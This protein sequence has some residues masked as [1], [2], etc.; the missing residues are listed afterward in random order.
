MRVAIIHHQYAKKGGMETYLLDLIEGFWAYGDVVTVI[1]CQADPELVKANSLCRVEKKNIWLPR[2]WRKFCFMSYINNFFRHDEYDLSLSLTRTASQNAV[3]CGGTHM[4]YLNYLQK[5]LVG[6]KD[7]IEIYF[8]RKS[9]NLSPYIVAHSS[10]LRDELISL[11][12]ADPTK[13][14]LFYPPVNTKAF[15]R[16]FREKRSMFMQKFALKTNKINLLFPSTGHKRKGWCELAKAMQLLPKEQFELI[17]VGSK[18]D[19]SKQSSNIRS[20]GFVH[21]M[22]ELYAAVDFTIL[23]SHYEPYGLIVAESLQCGTPVIISNKVGAQD[24]VTKDNGIII[25]EVTPQAIAQ[26]ILQ[27]AQQRFAVAED[28]A[29]QHGLVLAKHIDLL[30]GLGHN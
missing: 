4:G 18:I 23:P 29:I 17:V 1:T 9:Y 8:E 24:F 25:S 6:I 16:V 10:M 7:K 21:N 27:A 26:A 14:R 15:S 20:L 3:I 2:V 11:Y 5:K 22:A 30:R 19:E 12:G 13:I 28:F